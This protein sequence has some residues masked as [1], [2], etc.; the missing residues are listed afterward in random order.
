MPLSQH[1]QP[2]VLDL[3]HS[4]SLCPAAV[5][6][7]LLL[8]LDLHDDAIQVEGT[9]VHGQNHGH[10]EILGLQLMN[11]LLVQLAV[12]VDLIG[13]PF[14]LGLQLYLVHVSFFHILLDEDRFIPPLFTC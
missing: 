6:D 3:V 4:L 14:Q 5:G 1:R 2:V 11:L 13:Q 8:G 7:L 12:E 9:V 10:D